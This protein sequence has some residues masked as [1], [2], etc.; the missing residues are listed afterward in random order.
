[1][2]GQTPGA[3]SHNDGVTDL[4]ALTLKG[5]LEFT[6]RPASMDDAPGIVAVLQEVTAERVYSAIDRAW[7]VDEQRHFIESRSVREATYVAVDRSGQ[8]VGYQCLDRHAPLLTTMA[9]VGELGT[10]LKAEWRRRGVGRALFLETAA[11]ARSNS[12]RKL[13]IQVRAS[14][15]AGRSFYAGLG[16]VECGRLTRQVVIDGQDDDEIIMEFFL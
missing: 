12:Y 8:V 1:M 16:F 2:V 6:I 4:D 7:T 5:P 3:G 13:V 9:H 11:F 14:N 15:T 10:W